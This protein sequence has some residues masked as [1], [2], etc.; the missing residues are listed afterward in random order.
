MTTQTH[1][2]EKGKEKKK[3]DKDSVMLSRYLET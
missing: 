3:S 1:F 2:D